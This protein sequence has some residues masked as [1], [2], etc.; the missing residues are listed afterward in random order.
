ML[1]SGRRRLSGRDSTGRVGSGSG[2]GSGGSSGAA[3]TGQHEA[4]WPS[5]TGSHD[6]IALVAI[7][8]G[9]SVAAGASSN[10][11]IHKVPG[12]VGDA[13]VPGGGA[14]ADS[15]VGGCG[16]TGELRAAATC[17]TVRTA[18]ACLPATLAGCACQSMCS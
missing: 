16:S 2:T 14:Y 5:A 13:A 4:G 18:A 6:T 10:G 3:E 7:T 1:G 15:Q 11:A 17:L 8:A 12:R 9:G